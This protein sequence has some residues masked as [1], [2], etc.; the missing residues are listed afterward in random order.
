MNQIMTIAPYR[1]HGGWAFDDDSVGLQ[2]EPFVAG[3]PEI[4]D[5]YAGDSDKIV[6]RFSGEEFPG[7]TVHLEKIKEAVGG[8]WYR[9]VN[10]YK[11]GWLCPALFKY[12]NDAPTNIWA[13]VVRQ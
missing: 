8:N 5:D 4:I 1:H 9:D 7:A 13:E 2:Q 3:I 12:F 10:T 11:I 6:M